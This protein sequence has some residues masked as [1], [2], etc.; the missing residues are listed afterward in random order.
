[1][2]LLINF[3][4]K[5]K[6]RIIVLILFLVGFFFRT[7]KLPE[8][9]TFLGDQGRD[10]VVI[11]DIAMLKHFTAIGP[12]SSIGAVFLGP[13]YYYFMAPWLLVFKFNP[14]GLAF[15]VAI[16]NSVGIIVVYSLI[17]RIFNRDVAL[18]SS[19]IYSLS[20]ILIEF[21]RFSWNP[22]P[23][24]LFIF[25]YLYLFYKFIDLRLFNKHSVFLSL[26]TGF[27]FSLCVQ[28]H[29]SVVFLGIASFTAYIFLVIKQILDK[30][31]I[32]ACI[33][34][35]IVVVIGFVFGNSP[36]ILFDL[37]HGFLNFNSLIQM[38]SEKKEFTSTFSER[39]LSSFGYMINFLVGTSITNILSIIIILILILVFLFTEKFNRR[40]SIFSILFFISLIGT[41][42]FMDARIPHYYNIIYPFVII[43]LSYLFY[44]IKKFG[45]VIGVFITVVLIIVFTYL[46]ITKATFITR[47]GSNQI[48][49][50]KI[51]SNIIFSDLPLDKTYT[52]TTL[53]H[54]YD[55][56]P[57]RY[58]L[59]LEGRYPTSKE[60]RE[61]SDLL[62][63]ICP[64]KCSPIGDP[65]WDVA[66]FEPIK[67]DKQ[68]K[69]DDVTIYRLSR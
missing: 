4:K 24:P 63:V 1:M 37:R 44:L 40:A 18:F 17:K 47:K 20:Y 22:N 50:A 31:N 14:V 39:L 46:N 3:F 41:V 32:L 69:V 66:F 58:F 6:Y 61:K 49:R 12:V 54:R 59:E 48:G 11:K 13:F 65:G 2:E 23:L 9:A 26:I 57:Y 28:L 15:G 60:I 5:D 16:I 53:P 36:L 7:Y 30:K 21:S 51:V 35:S 33:R 68:W 27:F 8:Y 64:E 38:F 62:Y 34:N 42:L 19:I 10:A 55:D 52:L 29:Y 43:L 45:S 56:Y 25:I 67:I